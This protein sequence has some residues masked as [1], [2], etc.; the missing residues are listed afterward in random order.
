MKYLISL[1]KRCPRWVLF[2]YVVLVWLNIGLLFASFRARY[3]SDSFT[4]PAFSF[5]SD[6]VTCFEINCSAKNYIFPFPSQETFYSS[7]SYRICAWDIRTYD[8]MEFLVGIFLPLL[9]FISCLFLLEKNDKIKDMSLN[10][11]KAEGE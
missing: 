6:A 7:D 10:D 8:W 4:V 9:S 5:S 2:L 11:S 1:V 3:W